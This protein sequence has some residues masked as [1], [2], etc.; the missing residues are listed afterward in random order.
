MIHRGSA[1]RMACFS[2]LLF[3]FAGPVATTRGQETLTPEPATK[4]ASPQLG[5]IEEVM[6]SFVESRQISGAVTLVGHEGK[7][8]H[9]S[10]VGMADIEAERPMRTGTLFSIASM[11]KPITATALMMLVEEGKVDLDDPIAMH[12][13]VFESM[14]LA[15][16]SPPER[17]ITIRDTLTHTS[18]LAGSQLFSG[19]L[20]E[21]VDD[22]ATRPLAFQPGTKWQYS[23]GLNVAGRIIEVVSRQPFETFLDERIFAPLGMTQTTFFPDAKQRR[24][25]AV[26]YRPGESEGT[27]AAT[28]NRIVDV[29]STQGPNPSGG[30][31]STARDMFRFY[32]MI[33]QDGRSNGKR[34]LAKDSVK[35]MLTLQTGDLKTGFTPGNGWGLGWCL[36]QKPQ[37]VT[38]MLSP[39]TFGHG[40]AFGTQGWTDPDTQTI[41]VLMIQRTGMGN[42]DASEIRG[43]FQ[44]AANEALGL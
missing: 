27:L 25:L 22:L 26:I 43:A 41:Y 29:Q 5:G 30:L 4:K 31:M 8:V 6:R 39:G 20:A 34:I 11:T 44:R 3:L 40:G 21:A 1:F 16:G 15:D 42:S 35:E 24:R 28:A 37:E 9:L 33:L 13:P 38:S 23:P 19:T 2:S 14:K 12:L 18:G 17:P 36:V 7:I 10:A 32:R